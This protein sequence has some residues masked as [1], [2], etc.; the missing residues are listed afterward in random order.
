[1][2]QQQ[3]NTYSQLTKLYND[4]NALKIRLDTQPLVDQV[5]LFLRGA[6]LIVE[7]DEQ[8]GKIRTKKLDMGFPKCNDRGVQDLLQWVVMH[9]NPQT[10]QGN[11][12]VDKHGSSQKFEDFLY[13]FRVD[14]IT[15]IIRNA[16]NW[17]IMDDDIE[18]I[19]NRICNLVELFLSRLLA[20]KERES[21][22][23]TMRSIESNVMT[24]KGG[25][26]LMKG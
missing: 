11:F 8:T 9:V 24:N 25:I 1:M 10:V 7:Q 23:E 6:R 17:E 19:H 18:G 2:D 3:Q 14:L 26:P 20:N 12:Y 4:F 21:Y 5:E 15:E 16:Y 13:W 22:G